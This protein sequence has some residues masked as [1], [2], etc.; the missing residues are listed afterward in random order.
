MIRTVFYDWEMLEYFSRIFLYYKIYDFFQ[1][2]IISE[3]Q[4]KDGVYTSRM[5]VTV[6]VYAGCLRKKEHYGLVTVSATQNGTKVL[7]NL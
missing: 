6:T 7:Q 3:I 4:Y 2:L 1:G 5:R